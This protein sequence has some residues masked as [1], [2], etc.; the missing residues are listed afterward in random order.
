MNNMIFSKKL[1]VAASAALFFVNIS[2]FAGADRRDP[3]NSLCFGKPFAPYKK[4]LTKNLISAIQNIE[5]SA[6]EAI[7][8]NSP[9]RVNLPNRRGL[10][11]IHEA[12]LSIIKSPKDNAFDI[13]ISLLDAK[14]D[15]NTQSL[16]DCYT[17]LHLLYLHSKNG[18]NKELLDVLLAYGAN[19]LLEDKEGCKPIDLQYHP[20]VDTDEVDYDKE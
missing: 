3:R 17:P 2:I 11:P 18:I 9:D 14:A 1:V 15:I 12:V 13:L 20:D 8:K 7:C 10:Y 4:P 16:G 19:P 5:V 6:V